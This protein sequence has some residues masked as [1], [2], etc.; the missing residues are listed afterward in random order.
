MDA[1]TV[2][3]ADHPRAELWRELWR[4]LLRPR[5]PDREKPAVDAAGGEVR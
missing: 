5:P 4:R 3:T 2:I 1:L